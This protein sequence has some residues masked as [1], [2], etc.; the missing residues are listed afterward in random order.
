MECRMNSTLTF[1][2]LDR[3]ACEALLL[4][5]HV[6]RMAFTFRDR[7]DIEPLHYV[8]EDG[9]IYGR[10]TGG[11]KL[12]TLSHHPWVAFEVDEVSALFDWKSVV[13]HGRIEFPDPEGMGRDSLRH[14]KAVAA[15]RTLIP[16]AFSDDDP[17]P[18]RDIVWALPLHTVEGRMATTGDAE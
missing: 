5:H 13:V 6:G 8:Y 2:T 7:V 18:D 15:F 17:T 16:G 9:W 4:A 11:T 10:T 1:S 12:R 14:Q 3:A